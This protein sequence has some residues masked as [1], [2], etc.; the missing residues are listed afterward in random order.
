MVAVATAPSLD[1]DDVARMTAAVLEYFFMVVRVCSLQSLKSA[2][3]VPK[4]LTAFDFHVGG[5]FCTRVPGRG[6]PFMMKPM[7]CN[8]FL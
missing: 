6:L 5:I 2:V 3:M 8:N 4:M 1:D 7:Q